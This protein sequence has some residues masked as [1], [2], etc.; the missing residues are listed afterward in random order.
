MRAAGIV[1]GPAMPKALRHAFGVGG[2]Q[3][4]VPLNWLGHA[5]YSNDSDLQR[6]H[7]R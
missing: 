6:R 2:R 1:E 3:T 7:G 5:E 4:G